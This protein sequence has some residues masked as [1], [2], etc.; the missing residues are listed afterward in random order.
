MSTSRSWVMS[1]SSGEVA[2]EP[3][4]VGV[5]HRCP[6]PGRPRRT[7]DVGLAVGAVD[8][9]QPDPA[10][11]L[12]CRGSTAITTSSLFA[13]RRGLR[14]SA[15]ADEGAVHLHRHAG[16]AEQLPVGTHHR[17]AQ[18]VQ[19]RPGGLIGPE[20]QHPLQAQRGHPVLLGAHEP[21]R[22]EPGRTAAGTGGRS[23]AS[24]TTWLFGGFALAPACR[25][26]PGPRPRSGNTRLTRPASRRPPSGLV[27]SY[28]CSAR[29]CG[30]ASP[31]GADQCTR[32]SG[33]SA[34][35]VVHVLLQ[36]GLS[37]GRRARRRGARA[38]RATTSTCRASPRR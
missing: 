11:T 26:P 21:H 31:G 35:S 37:A 4:A 1:S 24:T 22:R 8:R 29:R 30:G 9:G 2:V 6:A 36:G 15:A 38:R 28:A 32:L 27:R 5:Q 13:Y 34:S 14:P 7:D 20:A 33:A 10:Q 17:P 25:R 12:G 18:L 19:P 16:T 3:V 23:C